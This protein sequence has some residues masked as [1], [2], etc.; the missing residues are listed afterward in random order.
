M[1]IA[2]VF[3]TWLLNTSAGEDISRGPT[4][5]T[6]FEVIVNAKG[7]DLNLDEAGTAIANELQSVNLLMSTYLEDSEISQFNRFDSEGWFPVSTP[8]YKVIARAQ[9]I[10]RASEGA[11]D[12]TIG[13]IVNR[14]SFGPN[15]DI[16]TTPDASETKAILERVG[17]QY[18]EL[19]AEPPAIR[20]LKPA[21]EIDLSGIA[22]GFAVDQVTARLE[23]LW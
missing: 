19:Q 13:P 21:L 8:T 3:S 14:W 18:L 22:K 11:F 16:E 17:Y 10:A 4:M 1:G 9:E 7:L 2:V 20:K 15:K 6:T 5:G 12:I 23:S